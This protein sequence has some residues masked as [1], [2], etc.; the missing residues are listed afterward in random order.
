[1]VYSTISVV[2]SGNPCHER[3]CSFLQ[4]YGNKNT[5]ELTLPSKKGTENLEECN[6]KEAFLRKRRA[7]GAILT[8]LCVLKFI[9]CLYSE[10]FR[11]DEHK[12]VLI[13]SVNPKMEFDEFICLQTKKSGTMIIESR[14][15]NDH[16]F[17]T[18]NKVIG[19]KMYNI[20]CK[21]FLLMENSKIHED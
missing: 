11:W 6:M 2:T 20:K 17:E 7:A 12:H 19:G 10:I 15:S 9:W 18:S 1:M 14:C 16:S 13:S 21:N 5:L 8:N 4:K 3:K